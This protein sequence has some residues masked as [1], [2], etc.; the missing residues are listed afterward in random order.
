MQ[1]K[2]STHT[3]IH[4]ER[5]RERERERQKGEDILE[6]I[7]KTVIKKYKI[8]ISKVNHFFNIKYKENNGILF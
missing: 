6:L 1:R 2:K 8:Y 4:R 3:Y 7:V 5:E